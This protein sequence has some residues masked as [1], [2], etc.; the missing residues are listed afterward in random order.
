MKRKFFAIII[1]AVFL[2]TNSSKVYSQTDGSSSSGGGSISNE[3]SVQDQTKQI[4]QDLTKLQ[5]KLQKK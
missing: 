2:I 1:S 4:I 5:A 3:P